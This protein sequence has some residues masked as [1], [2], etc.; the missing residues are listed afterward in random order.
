[1]AHAIGNLV[2]AR[3]AHGIAHTHSAFSEKARKYTSA[4]NVKQEQL[5]TAALN[6]KVSQSQGL[7]R[8]L[9]DQIQVLKDS[10]ASAHVSHVEL[11]E[12]LYAKNAPYELCCWRL[13]RRATRPERELK[14]DSFEL[15]LEQEKQALISAKHRLQLCADRTSDMVRSL[16]RS[17]KELEDDLEKKKQA[18][19]IDGDC[20]HAAKG[21]RTMTAALED[22]TTY[23]WPDEAVYSKE[24]AENDGKR[25][26]DTRLRIQRA[27]KFEQTAKILKDECTCLMKTI[28]DSCAASHA[29]TH[30]RM[31]ESIAELRFMRKELTQ[32]LE[33]TKDRTS[34]TANTLCLTA[35]EINKQD[36][37]FHLAVT[38]R[39]LRQQRYQSERI[40]DP[41]SNALDN[42]AVAMQKNM[43]SLLNRHGAEASAL[44]RLHADR[45]KLEADIEDKTKALLIDLDCEKRLVDS[46]SSFQ[47]RSE[48]KKVV[49]EKLASLGVTV[50]PD[51]FG[52]EKG[53]GPKA[54]SYGFTGRQYPRRP[55][56]VR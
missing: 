19:Q 54:A 9:K 1:M 10:V 2:S 12:A 6:K 43:N 30:K 20:I 22:R 53:D 36:E 18:V 5:V 52:G 47:P 25:E 51:K 24:H 41:V 38:R 32:A 39:K 40:N 13:E 56:S 26:F 46:F 37:P 44:N 17:L 35:G 8:L 55:H 48:Y 34:Q 49:K 15:A 29:N 16:G 23:I 14:R 11:Q 21:H 31:R 4:Q 7:V 42:Q 28:D 27:R 33:A 3:A 50:V 45:A